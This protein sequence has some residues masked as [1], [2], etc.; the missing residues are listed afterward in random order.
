MR[1]NNRCVVA[2]VAAIITVPVAVHAQ[3]AGYYKGTSADGSG[4]EFQVATDMATGLLAVTNA[5]VF[6]SAPCKGV[7]TT[8]NTGW[9]Y[10]LFADI[11]NRKVSNSTTTSYFDI[12]F[13]LVFSADGQTAQGSIVSISPDLYTIPGAT[14]ASRALFCTSPKQKLSLTYSATQVAHPMP[15][16]RVMLLRPALKSN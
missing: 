5:T 4:L 9:G 12:S 3:T 7:V 6:F 14:K 2:T 15:E 13:N 10:G 16:G 11:T 8:L 1:F